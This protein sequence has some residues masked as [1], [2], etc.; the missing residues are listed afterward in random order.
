MGDLRVQRFMGIKL[1]EGVLLKQAVNL[2]SANITIFSEQILP[3]LMAS[4]IWES[5]IQLVSDVR[6]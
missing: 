1:K 6:G 5:R 3:Q 4:P 2:W